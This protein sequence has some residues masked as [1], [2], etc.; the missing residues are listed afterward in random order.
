MSELAAPLGIA[1]SATGWIVTGE[2]DAHTA[3]ALADALFAPIAGQP[4]LDLGGVSF[5]DSSGLRV[6]VEAT[7]RARADGGDLVIVNATTAVAR[8]VTIGGL[9][10]H[11]TLR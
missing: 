10:D 5:M 1:S 8:L 4:T 9:A 2:V 3:P 11:L 7:K 6:L